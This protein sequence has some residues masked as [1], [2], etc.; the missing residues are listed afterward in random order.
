MKAK[1]IQASLRHSDISVALDSCAE[2]PKEEAREAL[3]KLPSLI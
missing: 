2:T 1:V 3:D